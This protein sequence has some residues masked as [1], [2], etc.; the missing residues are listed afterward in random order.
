[1]RLRVR[2][3]GILVASVMS[4]VALAAPAPETSIEASLNAL[5]P[6]IQVAGR[7]YPGRSLAQVMRENHVPSAS[8]AF[9][10]HGRIAWL[11]AYGQSDV[12]AGRSATTN[13]LYQAA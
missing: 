6:L 12:A 11:R 9:V 1:M 3:L 13:T 2:F 10:E 4:S 5:T 8:I 7:A